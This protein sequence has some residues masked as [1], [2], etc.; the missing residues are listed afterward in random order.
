MNARANIALHV[1]LGNARDELVADLQ[2]QNRRLQEENVNDYRGQL[3]HQWLDY[4]RLGE[5]I[6][7]CTDAPHHVT[8]ATNPFF[9]LLPTRL[10]RL[11]RAADYGLR[12]AVTIRGRNYPAGPLS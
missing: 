12:A 2:A 10:W 5:D 11:L 6:L 4:M 1:V 9:A 8:M 7:N 3:A